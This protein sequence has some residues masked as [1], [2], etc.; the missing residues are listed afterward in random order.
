ME[1]KTYRENDTNKFPD[2]LRYASALKYLQDYY[3]FRKSNESDFSYEKWA[4]ELGLN[5]RSS[6]RMLC[7]GQR[8]I[9][10]SFIETFVKNN[11]LNSKELDYFTLLANYQN[12]KSNILKKAFLDKISENNELLNPPLEIKERLQFLSSPVLPILQM[13]LAFKDFKA[14]ETNL[15]KRLNID[16]KILNPALELLSDMGIAKSEFYENEKEAVWVSKVKHYKISDTLFDE[17]IKLF[18]RNSVNEALTMM[19]YDSNYTKFKSLMFSLPSSQFI[20]LSSDIEEFCN[21][22]KYKYG[23]DFI[24]NKKIYKVNIQ[25]Y[26]ITEDI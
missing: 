7:N 25:S 4:Q 17:A 9:S 16:A 14:T 1:L 5:S 12:T 6:L 21:K 22:L 13:L 19:E 3:K 23:N 10:E 26:P 11:N 20:D 15:K 18:H 2:I 24:E 8:I